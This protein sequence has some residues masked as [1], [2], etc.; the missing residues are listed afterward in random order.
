MPS[1]EELARNAI[2][3]Q[4][5]EVKAKTPVR[6]KPVVPELKEVDASSLG[7]PETPA[8]PTIM[9]RKFADLD[10]AI[11]R[12]KKQMLENVINP[13]LEAYEANK[14]LGSGGEDAYFNGDIDATDNWGIPAE[15]VDPTTNG[16]AEPLSAVLNPDNRQDFKLSEEDDFLNDDSIYGGNETMPM[17][18]HETTP[19]GNL[20]TVN[21]TNI[22]VREV[23][24]YTTPAIIKSEFS[25]EAVPVTRSTIDSKN[26]SM[27][28][29]ED[30]FG[31]DE[32]ETVTAS[33]GSSESSEE[34][35]AE[36]KNVIRSIKKVNNVVDL[37]AFKI[38]TKPVNVGNVKAAIDRISVPT[39]KWVNP[40][41]ETSYV[42]SAF[43]GTEIDVL[44]SGKKA[45]Q[46]DVMRNIEVIKLFYSHIVSDKPATWEAWAKTILND[47]FNRLY[48]GAFVACF[49]SAN[50]V[51][52]QCEKKHDF[53]KEV[54]IMSMVKFKDDEAKIKFN[55]IM[56]SPT[57]GKT[58]ES[59]LVQVSDDFAIAFRRPTV[60]NSMIEEYHLPESTRQKLPE[61]SIIFS[62]IE[63][64]YLIDRANGDLRPVAT[65]PEPGDITKTVKNRFKIYYDIL[66]SL[67]SD[68]LNSLI[69]IIN[70]L[71]KGDDFMSYQ[72]P[73]T[74]CD[75][76][77]AKI[78]AVP[79]APAD[80]L[81]IRHQLQIA[82]V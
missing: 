17:D 38:S 24:T 52:F 79:M 43:K 61:I 71:H 28:D 63:N 2:P 50:V 57:A 80:I 77:N 48:F 15:L 49:N 8:P 66:K 40:N 21:P 37:K 1:L 4:P 9:Q 18:V 76:C 23:E 54:D 29:D 12:D 39:A 67:T 22:Q 74:I 58:I 26:I 35:I 31:E 27:V 75:K 7:E 68:Q 69:P 13:A 62:H 59:E 5:E 6:Y 3:A 44:A 82:L 36:M 64:I 42:I 33:E 14:A 20:T 73:E 51:P 47:D 41:A 78:E 34:D 45:G 32:A 72:Y 53:M 25:P 19:I 46:T 11:E 56:N 55:K 81:F 70:D 16:Q 65:N 60:W 30:I 10:R